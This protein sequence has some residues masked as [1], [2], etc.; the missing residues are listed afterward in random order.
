MT[1]SQDPYCYS[2]TRVLKNLGNHQNPNDLG[3]FEAEAMTLALIELSETPLTLPFGCERLKETHRRLFN[4]IYPW[5]G[6]FREHTSRMTKQRDGY[7]VTYGDA[8]HIPRELEKVFRSLQREHDL[9]GLNVKTF[10]TRTAH[11]YSEIDAIHPFR[12]GNSRTLRPFFTDLARQ[13]GYDLDWSTIVHH[14]EGRKDFYLARDTAVIH[15][16]TGFLTSLIET[17]ISPLQKMKLSQHVPVKRR[18]LVMNGQRI[19]QTQQGSTTWK[20][21]SVDQAKTLKPGI[22]PLDQA[23]QVDQTKTYEGPILHIDTQSVYQQLGKQ[24]VQHDRKHFDQTPDIA[25][26]QRITYDSSIAH[27]QT[28]DYSNQ[29]KQKHTRSR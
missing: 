27:I 3:V 21:E 2:G 17:S 10:A 24:V 26:Y 18:L 15:A 4:C 29:P 19:V 23:R 9:Q 14:N 16:D 6:Q 20:T 8:T 12:E 22:Y 13:A 7:T 1:S 5:A 11:Y 28:M 25:C